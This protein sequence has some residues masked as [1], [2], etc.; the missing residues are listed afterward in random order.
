MRNDIK[1]LLVERQRVGSGNRSLKTARSL[2][3]GLEYSDDFDAGPSVQRSSRA[4]YGW[5]MKDLNENL[6]PLYQFLRKSV[7][8][9]WNRVYSEIRE[10]VDPRRTIGFHV[11]QHVEQFVLQDVIVIRRVPYSQTDGKE[12]YGLYVHPRTGI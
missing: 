7:G 12:F 3:A 10:Q 11:L 6:R 8:K 2:K 1:Y 4:A 9:H 5:N